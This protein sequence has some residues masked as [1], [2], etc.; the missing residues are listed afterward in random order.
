MIL[1]L[2]VI[3]VLCVADYAIR[4]YLKQYFADDLSKSYFFNDS[5][6]SEIKFEYN[7]AKVDIGISSC[8]A[9]GFVHFIDDES[10]A[11]RLIATKVNFL[12]GTVY[13]IIEETDSI[14]GKLLID[15]FTFK[16]AYFLDPGNNNKIRFDFNEN[17]E[18]I[19]YKKGRLFEGEYNI[20]AIKC[21]DCTDFYEIANFNIDQFNAILHPNFNDYTGSILIKF[22]KEE[23]YVSIEGDFYFDEFGDM[24]V[25]AKIT[26]SITNEIDRTDLI[27]I[28][29]D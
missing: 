11:M 14:R 4:P 13:S 1:G 2:A 8:S 20:T 10:S 27:I 12:D 28:L 17:E 22:S 15:W 18:L 23:G 24:V 26:N 16:S 25:D 5:K 21:E 6:S 3:I 7:P 9:E 29:E 19:Y